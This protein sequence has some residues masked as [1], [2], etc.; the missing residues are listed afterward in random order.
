MLLTFQA[1]CIA[2]E[3]Y[4]NFRSIIDAISGVVFLGTPHSLGDEK[5]ESNILD[6]L[7]RS[8]QRILPK[9]AFVKTDN[10]ALID[11][12]RQFEVVNL[13]IPVISVYEGR[14][15]KIHD[16]LFARFR[17]SRQ[18]IVSA[19]IFSRAYGRIRYQR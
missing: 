18:S 17:K 6:L 14:E 16:S 4:Y 15:T 11:L 9:H 12:S 7:L 1:L 19:I 10:A 2:R 8:Q 3:R 5:L 13:Q